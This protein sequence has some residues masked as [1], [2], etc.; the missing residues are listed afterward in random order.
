[1]TVAEFLEFQR[2]HS[3]DCKEVFMWA[4]ATLNAV[5]DGHVEI[6]V[7]ALKST[8]G[9]AYDNCISYINS[10]KDALDDLE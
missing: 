6:S 2:N 3:S 5:N 9:G 8:I 4:D 1:M 10:M 7:A